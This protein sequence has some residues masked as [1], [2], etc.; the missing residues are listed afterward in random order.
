MLGRNA[1]YG[2]NQIG[3]Q[4]ELDDGSRLRFARQLRVDRFVRPTAEAARD[5]NAMQY[6]GPSD[7]ALMRKC[8]LHDY[9]CAGLHRRGRLC[10]RV[11]RHFPTINSN[12]FQT[13]FREMIN[14]AL[15]M[16]RPAL[17]QSFQKRVPALRLNQRSFS[18]RAF[19]RGEVTAI[20]VADKVCRTQ[21][22]AVTIFPHNYSSPGVWQATR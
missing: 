15:L 7:P 4:A 11:V 1:L 13:G 10:N 8:P 2:R 21:F 20:Q 5:F 18:R 3:I 22:E 9:A 6:V 19:E 14:I 12:G 16:C 17:P